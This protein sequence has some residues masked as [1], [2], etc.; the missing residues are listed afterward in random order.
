MSLP[1]ELGSGTF[2]TSDAV[3]LTGA[4]VVPAGQLWNVQYITIQQPSTGVLKTLSIGRGTTATAANVKLSRVI[5]AGQYSE[6]ILAPFK[7]AAGQ[8]LNGAVSAGTTE[9]T[10]T[11]QGTKDLVA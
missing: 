10:Y 5:A 9:L 6:V 11:I 7:L 8:G 4:A 3:I 1:S 2:T